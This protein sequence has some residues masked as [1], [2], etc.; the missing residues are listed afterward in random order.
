[1]MSLKYYFRHSSFLRKYSADIFFN[2]FDTPNVLNNDRSAIMS[3]I[4]YFEKNVQRIVHFLM[5]FI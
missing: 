2:D 4:E 5:H 1:M 3:R